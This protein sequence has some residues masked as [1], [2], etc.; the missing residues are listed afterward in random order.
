[1]D[2]KRDARGI[3][4]KG[5]FGLLSGLA[6]LL[7]GG[8]IGWNFHTVWHTWP[9]VDAEVVG[10][11]VKVVTIH[12]AVRGGITT[13]QFRP[14]IEFRY[15]LHE[16]EYVT[17]AWLGSSADS[18][19]EARKTLDRYP[20]GSHQVIRYSPKDPTD[21]RFGTPGFTIPAFSV[22]LMA[23]GLVL[24]AMEVRALATSAKA[25][26]SSA[27][28][29]WQKAR[30]SG[31]SLGFRTHPTPR[32][33]VIGTIRCPSCGRQV[34]ADRDTCSNCLKSLRAA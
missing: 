7:V 12:P 3:S 23:V 28:G 30:V 31:R 2:N 33:D 4:G 8:W 17:K 25:S 15:T 6:L 19:Q 14:T 13:R 1:M 5:V 22:V 24:C 32:S 9:T 20:A 26:V 18:Y 29:W 21:L 27:P 11:D 34:E 16:K 10:G